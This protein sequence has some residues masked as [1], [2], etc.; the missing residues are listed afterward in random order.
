MLFG[1]D[2]S[3]RVDFEKALIQVN[4]LLK[5]TNRY[6]IF[7]EI[8]YVCTTHRAAMLEQCQINIFWASYKCFDFTCPYTLAMFESI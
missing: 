6:L 1:V 8:N 5:K 3:S 7:Y 2:F 4:N